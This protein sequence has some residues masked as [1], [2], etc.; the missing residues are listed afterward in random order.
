M[1]TKSLIQ[2]DMSMKNWIWDLGL[3]L[4]WFPSSDAPSGFYLIPLFPPIYLISPHISF[5]HPR[6]QLRKRL[7]PHEGSAQEEKK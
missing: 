1:V 2:G 5:L 4:Q 7:G 6:F 3:Y